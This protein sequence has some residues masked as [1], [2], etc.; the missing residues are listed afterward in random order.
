MTAEAAGVRH[1][2]TA[3]AADMGKTSMAAVAEVIKVIDVMK[4]LMVEVMSIEEEV[5]AIRAV[6]QT[7][8]VR[9]ARGIKPILA[10]IGV[11]VVCAP[12]KRDK[13]DGGNR[14]FGDPYRSGHR[15]SSRACD[16]RNMKRI[17]AMAHMSACRRT[18]SAANLV[19]R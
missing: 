14:A 5:G 15:S 7:I 16:R 18:I 3:E 1:M 2:N 11:L 8:I 9:I 10:G 13:R 19:T 6:I 4:R 12:G 17:S